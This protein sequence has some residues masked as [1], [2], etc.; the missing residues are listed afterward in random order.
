MRPAVE[1]GSSGVDRHSITT[2]NGDVLWGI[3]S[4]D[5]PLCPTRAEAV[6]KDVTGVSEAFREFV[7]DP[8]ADPAPPVGTIG[9]HCLG[10]KN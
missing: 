5:S 1:S 6:I 7:A 8:I 9:F 10:T 2:A 4:S 3:S